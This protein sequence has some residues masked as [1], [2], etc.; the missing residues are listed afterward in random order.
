[1]KPDR[2]VISLT[3]P[4]ADG[5][6]PRDDEAPDS[7][8]KP[9]LQ[10]QVAE[11]VFS[12]P[13][14]LRPYFAQVRTPS[15]RQVT[16]NHPPIAGVDANDHD[17]MHPGIWLAFGDIS[18]HDFWRNKGRIQHVRFTEPPTAKDN[19]LSFA[20]ESRL[21]T[22]EGGTLCRMISRFDLRTRP[23]GWLLA[24]EATF[25]SATA[26]FAFGDQE[27]MGFGF[28]AATELTETSGGT[29]VSSAGK[30]GAAATWGQAA[31]WCDVSGIV[32]GEPVG[33]TLVPSPDNFRVS[34][35]H[36]RDYGLLVANP[37]GRA[38]MKQG[39]KSEVVVAAGESWEI[40]FAAV[41]HQGFS[42][43]PASFVTTFEFT[44]E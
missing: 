17:T 6:N 22:P 8:R 37:F 2:L 21:L 27:E 24:W 34:W 42:F 20:T 3:A 5:R 4:P 35:W 28:R 29:I 43:D 32:G 19:L 16:R 15:G 40:A 38:A 13:N 36:N 7:R 11:F 41:V 26:E 33:V 31:T 9:D 39:P 30:I 18:G 25:Q 23:A 1:K 12:D 14:I 10:T 44:G